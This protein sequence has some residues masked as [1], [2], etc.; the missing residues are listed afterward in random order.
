M[1]RPKLGALSSFPKEYATIIN[2]VRNNNKGFGPD[3]ILEEIEDRFKIPSDKLPNR[4]TVARYLKEK[5]HVKQYEKHSEMPITSLF[6][7]K[8]AH[9]LWQLDGRGNEQVKGLGTVALLDIID[10]YSST[11][12]QCYPAEIASPFGH[13]DTVDYKT[14]L[15]LAFIEFGMPKKLQV[16]HA[17]VF[18]ENKSKS[19]FPT[20]FHLWLTSLG[21]KLCYSRVHRPTDQA[22]VERS[23]QTLYNQILKRE[24]AFE[25]LEDLLNFCNERRKK[26]NHRLPSKSNE[27]KAPLVAHPTAKHSQ[28]VYTPCLEAE[29]IDMNLVYKFLSEG[30]WYRKVASNGTV[31]LGGQVYYISAN[32]AKTEL[33]ITFCATSKNLLFH[34][35]KDH[36]LA[37]LP[38]KGISLEILLAGLDRI[39]QTPNLQLTLPLR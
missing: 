33:K 3:S 21:I 36:C 34:D 12:A 18:F 10:V 5:G 37:Q 7:P 25:N 20:L 32:K 22:K 35:V 29:L 24:K 19:P 1:G 16:D 4:S 14:A 8:E 27:G 11:Y 31:C 2:D 17:S 30:T 23:H 38:I 39:Y 13:P 26:L 9:E 28:R 6:E 15:R